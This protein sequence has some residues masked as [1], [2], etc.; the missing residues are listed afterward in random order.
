MVTLRFDNQIITAQS[1]VLISQGEVFI[2]GE[3]AEIVFPG[4]FNI[5][6]VEGEMSVNEVGDIL[7]ESIENETD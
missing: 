2:D 4:E 7:Y 6:L 5:E 3:L 1:D